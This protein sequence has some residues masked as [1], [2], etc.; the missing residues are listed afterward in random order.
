MHRHA[1]HFTVKLA[2]IAI[3]CTA[4]I[5]PAIAQEF[6]IGLGGGLQGMHYSLQNGQTKPL[7]GGAIDLR[8]SFRLDAR[9]N[10]VSGLGAGTYRT[11]ATLQDGIAYSSYLVD[12]TG[13]AF[14]FNVKTT[15]YKETQQF[16]A[17]SVPVLLQFHTQD[18]IVQWYI[19]GGLKGF[20]P[21]STTIQASATQLVLSGYYPDYN[22][23]ISNLPQH[24]FGT[25][26][27]WSSGATAKLNPSLALSLATGASFNLAPGDRLYAGVFL[28]YGLT[29]LKSRGDSLPLVSYNPSGMNG[30]QAGSVLNSSYSGKPILFSIGVQLRLSFGASR[31]KPATQQAQLPVKDS[32]SSEMEELIEEPVVFGP[33]GE[34][35]VPELAKKH[36]DELAELLKKFSNLRISIVGHV[37]NDDM[38]TEDKKVGVER[39]RSV[40]DYLRGRGIDAGRMDVS[41]VAVTEVFDS[42][43]PLSNYRN[44][45]ATI[46]L[47]P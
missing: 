8:Y 20:I 38:E 9:W 32:V 31:S 30:I 23:E 12:A 43:N 5:S 13:S 11:E 4:M 1:F 21:F 35:S 19:E 44:R 27:N 14:K 39:A 26:N 18:P 6:G 28:D 45:R 16:Y 15:G 24:G 29:S 47:L 37:C 34:T 2:E 22:I 7:F 36:L 10:L 46:K 41:P 25:I 42:E 17:F 3:I 33:L 40:A